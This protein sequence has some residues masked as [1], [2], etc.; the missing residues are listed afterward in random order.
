[1]LMS[2]DVALKAVDY[3]TKNSKGRRNIEI[4]FFGGE[5]L[6]NFDVVKET[7]AYG[8]QV[9]K[10]TGKHF[11]FTITTTAPFSTKKINI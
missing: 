9:E 1:M 3:L 4:D 10:I 7:V 5:P 6:M 2:K 8:R 11:Y